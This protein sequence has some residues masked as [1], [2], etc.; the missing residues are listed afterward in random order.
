[1]IGRRRFLLGAGGLLTAAFVGKAKAFTRQTGGP[2]LLQ[3]QKAEETL[4]V[5]DQPWNDWGKW[6][7]SLGP[8]EDEAPPAPTWRDYLTKKG[9]RLETQADLERVLHERYVYADDLDTHIDGYGWED[10]WEAFHSPQAKAHHLLKEIDLGFEP[11]SKLKLAGQMDFVE[12]GG[13]PG[14]SAHWVD[15]QD[16]LT[17]SLLQA[18]LIELNLPIKIVVAGASERRKRAHY[19]GQRLGAAHG[20]EACGARATPRRGR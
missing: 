2:L 1:M 16:D 10:E 7:V 15:L 19:A 6:R 20:R 17:V 12:H 18:R 8:D 5:Y 14:S 9:Y 11:D 13:H 4:Y 3:P